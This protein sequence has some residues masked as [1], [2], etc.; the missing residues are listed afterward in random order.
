MNPDINALLEKI[1]RMEEE[2]EAEFARRRSLF[3]YH[4]E[5]NKVLFEQEIQRHHRGLRQGIGAFLKGTRLRDLVSALTTY[6][7]I[8]PL[9][10][11]DLFLW[12]YQ[13]TSFA[14]WRIPRVARKDYIVIDRH[15][16]AYLNGIEKLNCVYC[17]YANGLAAYFREVAART[18]QYWCPIKHARRIQAAHPRYALFTDY[19]DADAW[20]RESRERELRKRL[21]GR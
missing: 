6:A 14:I 20:R 21:R 9:V 8:L 19:G 1:S 16:L 5:R 2:L 10:F 7:M 11:L 18:E 15:Q 13:H 17:G 4:F 3:H 12:M